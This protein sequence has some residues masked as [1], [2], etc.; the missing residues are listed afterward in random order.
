MLGLSQP[1]ATAWMAET[2]KVDFLTILEAGSPS[3]RCQQ[4]WFL[5]RPPSLVCRRPPCFCVLTWSSLC[6]CVLVSSYEHTSQTKIRSSL[7]TS[8]ALITPLGQPMWLSSLVPPSVQGLILETQDPVPH[9]APCMEPA[10]R[11]ACV[12]ASLPASLSLCLFYLIEHGCNSN[13]KVL[14]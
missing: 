6:A 9:Q 11:S 1:N 12:S 7:M 3:S 8:L 10:S 2:T 13:F 4:G 5:L 14:D